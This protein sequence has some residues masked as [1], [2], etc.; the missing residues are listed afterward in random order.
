MVLAHV[1]TD[2]YFVIYDEIEET[3]KLASDLE[4]DGIIKPNQ[5]S[6]ALKILKTYKKLCEKQNINEIYAYALNFVN[7]AKNQ[8]SFIEEIES[9]CSLQF[10]IIDHN[11]QIEA[12]YLAVTNSIDLSRGILINIDNNETHIIRY[13]RRNIIDRFILP[14]GAMNLAELFISYST[15]P[16]KC[17]EEMTNFIYERLGETKFFE[18]TEEEFNLVGIGKVFSML[19]KLSKKV[20][21]YSIDLDHNYLMNQNDFK[22]VFDIIKVLDIDKTKK[23]KGI[24]EERADMLASGLCIIRGILKLL[25]ENN[26]IY[27]ACGLQEGLIYKVLAD[28]TEEKSLADLLTTS[29]KSITSFYNV[30]KQNGEKVAEI[31]NLVFRQLKVL[32]KLSRPYLRA[33]KIASYLYACGESVCLSNLNKSSA[34]IVLN[35]N[36]YGAS[37]KEIVLAS[38]ILSSL[39]GNEFNLA[40]WVKYKD[41]FV[42]ADLEAMKRLAVI[43]KIAIGLDLTQ[44]GNITDIICDVLGDSVIMKTT[45]NCDISFEIKHALRS[46]IDFK[47]AFGK[48]LEIL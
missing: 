45:A 29:L 36:I 12:M 26:I 14:Y 13:N 7:E 15:D 33:L 37:H 41:V 34:F 9:A 31:S 38:F 16:E 24:S 35:S 8:R 11:E 43:L 17:C 3:I 22:N 10:T 21:K 46:S 44:N 42:D 32:H 5:I 48:Y 1:Q 19:T 23:L 28:N 47:K 39:N 40:E 6:S 27:S 30:S 2:K 20:K 18:P 25:P 4:R